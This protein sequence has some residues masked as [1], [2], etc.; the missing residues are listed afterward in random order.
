MPFEKGQSGNPAGRPPKAVE[1]AKQSVLRELFDEQAERAVV[2]NMLKLAKRSGAAQAAAA[3]SAATWLWD[4]KYGKVKEQM[5]LS[6]SL[7]VKGYV[8]VSPDDWPDSTAE[9]DSDV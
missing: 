6:G 3:I 4:R 8:N 7:A 1:D 5:E 2:L 9:P